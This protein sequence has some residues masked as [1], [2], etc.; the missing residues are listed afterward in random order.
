MLWLAVEPYTWLG[1]VTAKGGVTGSAKFW[2]AE[3]GLALSLKDT[4]PVGAVGDAEPGP[5]T[6]TVAVK[7]TGWPTVPG[8][9]SLVTVVVVA[10]WLTCWLVA[11]DV[12]LPTKLLSP[13]YEAVTGCDPRA[14]ELVV[15][16]AWPPETPP[17]PIDSPLSKK[18]IVPVS[19]LAEELS[20]AVKVTVC[21]TT[22][23]LAE[24]PTLSVVAA[25][26]TVRPAEVVELLAVNVWSP[27][28]VAEIECVPAPSVAIGRVAVV[29][30]AVV[31]TEELPMGVEDP[32][33]KK[34]TVLLGLTDALC[35]GLTVA[36]NVTL[37][38]KVDVGVDD[39]TVVVVEICC[40]VSL[41]VPKLVASLESP[42]YVARMPWVVFEP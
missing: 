35:D 21:P 27:L 39:T 23:G 10:A 18:V 28:Y 17:V 8:S 42:L 16:V 2:Q 15:R 5:F 9:S 40:S 19:P 26:P 20:V 4:V 32:L 31:D 7:S 13:G 14:S 37:W 3:M 36:V 12:E 24:L 41:R 38:P 6:V 11:A 22:D 34:L 25:C 29:T 33:S 30:P 1:Q